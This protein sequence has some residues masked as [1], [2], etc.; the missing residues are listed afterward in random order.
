MQMEIDQAMAM[1]NSPEKIEALEKISK[2]FKSLLHPLHYMNTGIRQSLIEMYG[3]VNGYGIADLPDILLEHKQ[4]IC[5]L[6]LRVL[7]K[8][9]P[10]ISRSRAF[11]L[12]EMH[13]PIVLLAKSAFI[14][15][16]LSPE[17]LK[18]RLQSAIDVLNECVS[19][20]KYED[21]ATQEGGLCALAEKAVEQLGISVD[22]L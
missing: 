1:E 13:V 9:E 11:T 6:V 19:I 7:N 8:F 2:K 4:D 14:A 12:Y 21:K 3:R 10:G 5:E 18:D 16:V 17:N 15:G 22:S 20:L